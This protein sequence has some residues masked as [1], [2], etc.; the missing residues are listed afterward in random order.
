MRCAEL[1]TRIGVAAAACVAASALVTSPARA[2]TLTSPNACL[3]SFNNEYRDQPITLG[4]SGSPLG[5]PAGAVA[6]LSGASVSARL[7]ETLPRQGYELGVFSP[8]LN[9]VPSRVWVA[10]RGAGLA[11]ASQVFALTVTASTTITVDAGGNFVSG[12]PIEVTVP[13]PDSSWTVTGAEP[14]AFSQAGAGALPPLPVGIDNAVV[15]VAGS[16]VV[17]PKLADLRFVLDCV[18][19]VT[20]ADRKSYS[21]VD[22][23]A[24]AT[25][26][27]PAPV[28]PA[29]PTPSPSARAPAATPKAARPTVASTR[30]RALGGTVAVA[31]ACPA[32]ATPCR[33]RL[34]LRSVARLRSGGRLR[35]VSVA[36]PG[37]YA[38]APGSRRT[39]RLRLS[40]AARALLRA[41]GAMR[42]RVT[43]V[44]TSHPP[45]STTLRLSR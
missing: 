27:A 10:L 35:Q 19:G 14:V 28:A 40:S 37:T 32:R 3:Y 30:L 34:S 5:A 17:A 24:F 43:L 42:V 16:I 29:A 4:G 8:G 12:T 11:P 20:S 45:V 41:G 39:T 26:E 25:L 13:I 44:T 7:P 38:V 1:L 9:L 18:P 31:V 15:P 23:A 22:A 21:A 2:G 36:V 6:V 33:G